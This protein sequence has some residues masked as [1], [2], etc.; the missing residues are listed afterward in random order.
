V[1]A[2]KPQRQ[3]VSQQKGLK[4]NEDEFVYDKL[5]TIQRFFGISRTASKD[6][7]NSGMP[8]R[9]DGRYDLKEIFDWWKT[10]EKFAYAMGSHEPGGR[11]NGEDLETQKLA[12]EVDHRRLKYL[13]EL[14]ELVDRDAAKAAISQ[15]F[16]RVRARLLAAP[17]E[18]A[19]SLPSDMRA[20]Y[21][22]DAKHRVSLILREMELWS[23]EKEVEE[24]EDAT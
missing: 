12:I 24:G 8:V 17:E 10:T 13:R 23:F 11:A 14:N 1:E 3:A 16:H 20:A 19:S 4:V 21:I 6:W 9:S 18:L 5:V 15:M 2:G 7:K 22:E